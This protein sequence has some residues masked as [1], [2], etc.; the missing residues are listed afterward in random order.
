VIAKVALRLALVTTFRGALLGAL[1]CG[2]GCGKKA[3]APAAELTGLAAVPASAE[4]VIGADVPKIAASP[5]V[6][7]AVDQLLARDAELASR[8]QQLHDSCKL[9]ATRLA[10]LVLAIGPHPGPQPGT[11]PVLA[12]ATGKLS[13]TDF[14]TCV[15]AMVGQGGGSLVAKE[16]GGRTLYEA[17]QGTHVLYFA[18]GRADTLVLGADEAFVNEALGA[19]KKA[20]DNPDLKRWLDLVD[21]RAPL[22]AA[23]RVDPRVSQ[24]LPRATGGQV[25]AGPTAIAVTADLTAG[26]KVN[27]VVV[28]ANDDDAKALESFANAQKALL[29]YAAQA[30][31]LGKLVDKLA[32]KSERD[33]V[34]VSLDLDLDDINQLV[35][36][37]DGEGSAAQGS[38]PANPDTHGSSGSGSGS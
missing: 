27:A 5:L 22:W 3:S 21:Q 20:L 1:L 10:H 6:Q 12:V 14:A 31:S 11:G 30:K 25:H 24:G 26:A 17:R 7:H 33:L 34:R 15:R 29:A 38:P 19:G 4:V 2:Y 18:F 36:V 28:M 13:E 9:D 35:S 16:V 23:G 37:L 32:V 8:W